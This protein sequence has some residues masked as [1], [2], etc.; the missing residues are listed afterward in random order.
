MDTIFKNN[1]K[2]DTVENAGKI[3]QDDFF[4]LCDTIDSMPDAEPG[5][6]FPTKKE[7]LDHDVNKNIYMY[8]PYL[9]WLTEKVDNETETFAE[10]AEYA[11]KLMK[12]AV[13]E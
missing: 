2:K 3:S 9:L 11:N 8:L 12:Q 6:Y 13:A 10:M 4:E 5:E 7:L 1:N